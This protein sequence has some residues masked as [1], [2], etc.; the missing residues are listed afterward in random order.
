MQPSESSIHRG[1]GRNLMDPV[2]VDTPGNGYRLPAYHRL[3]INLGFK[4]TVF[5]LESVINLSVYNAYNRLNPF[6]QYFEQDYDPATKTSKLVLKQLTLFP[7][8]PSIA[9]NFSF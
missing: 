8:I 6:A 2:P 9:W 3:D 1:H 5:G 4:T 7:I